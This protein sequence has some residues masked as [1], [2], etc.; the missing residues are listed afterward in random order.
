MELLLL[1]LST[2]L[3][4]PISAAPIPRR[5]CSF[6]APAVPSIAG[7]ITS[8]TS[9]ELDRQRQTEY[10]RKS[11]KWLESAGVKWLDGAEGGRK[12]FGSKLHDEDDSATSGYS[13]GQV[14]SVPTGQRGAA[15]LNVESEVPSSQT[16]HH[17]DHTFTVS[18]SSSPIPSLKNQP[19]DTYE[20][21]LPSLSDFL[22]H[23]KTR[24]G[25][26]G[27]SRT[28]VTCISNCDSPS[29]SELVGSFDLPPASSLRNSAH[30]ASHAVHHAANRSASWVRQLTK[31]SLLFL[32]IGVLVA[33]G[34]ALRTGEL[35]MRLGRNISGGGRLRLGDGARQSLARGPRHRRTASSFE[36]IGRGV[37]AEK[38]RL[39]LETIEEENERF[40]RDADNE[41]F[42]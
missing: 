7:K 42:P 22:L 25:P 33:I 1:T 24:S 13:I 10:D 21:A 16:S 28:H 29:L 34:F 9:A 35:L 37:D 36:I 30:R 27:Q 2:I 32:A 14:P 3:S 5:D 18:M 38:P 31:V 23:G 20:E 39:D 12:D 4:L 17:S 26:S 8:C 40:L 6:P 19:Y 15:T 41:D 11:D